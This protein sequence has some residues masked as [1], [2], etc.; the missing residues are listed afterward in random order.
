MKNVIVTGAAGF[1]G[2]HLCDKLLSEG[3]S[4]V[5]VDN[6]GMKLIDLNKGEHD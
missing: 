3:H 4:V 2:Y 1:L 5:G 6:Y